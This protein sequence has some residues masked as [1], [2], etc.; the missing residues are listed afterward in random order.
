MFAR[1]KVQNQRHG[2]S[3]TMKYVDRSKG[4]TA[5][6][7]DI[8]D[9]LLDGKWHSVEEIANRTCKPPAVVDQVL[10]FLSDYDLVVL[11]PHQN[12]MLP[13]DIRLMLER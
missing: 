8:F 12:V 5:L 10:Q 9:L 1:K 4:Y 7:Q 6:S 2:V 11:D 13:R 3:A